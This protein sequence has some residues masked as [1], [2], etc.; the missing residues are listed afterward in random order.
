MTDLAKQGY[1]R[2]AD[3]KP[4]DLVV[5]IEKLHE[6]AAMEK[7]IPTLFSTLRRLRELR[8]GTQGYTDRLNYLRLVVGSEMEDAW[9]TIL[10]NKD[11]PASTLTS[12]AVP[13]SLLRALAAYRLGMQERMATELKSITSTSQLTV[14][15]RAILARMKTLVGEDVAAFRLSESIPEKLLLDEERAFGALGLH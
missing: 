9:T 5:I 11:I 2:I 12:S 6:L 8:P 15:Q 3:S 7:D 1:Q 14:G 10:G 13:P 4:R